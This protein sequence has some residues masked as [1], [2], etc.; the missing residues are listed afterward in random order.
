MKR[1]YKV[2]AGKL[3]EVVRGGDDI[4]WTPIAPM[5]DSKLGLFSSHEAFIAA[6][7]WAMIGA[8]PFQPKLLTGR[9]KTDV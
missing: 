6:A 1:T 9:V 8:N 3:E 5:I 4:V 7:L 2:V